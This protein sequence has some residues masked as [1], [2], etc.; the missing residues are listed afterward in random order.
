MRPIVIASIV[1][2]VSTPLT[3]QWLKQPT[4]GI[5]RTADGKPSLSAPSPQ[6]KDGT[7]D[8]SGLWL[9]NTPLGYAG[10][11]ATD[12]E[13]GDIQPWAGALYKQRMEDFG[14]DDPGTIGCLPLGPRHIAGIG[15]A[16]IIQAP[17]VIV[18]L[19]EDLTYRQIFLDGRELPKDP[20]PSWMG[21]SVGHWEGD[22]LVVESLG[23]NDRTWLDFG[24]HPHTEALRMTERFRRLDFGHMSVQ[25]MI[26]D[27][28][29]YAK[30]WSITIP[31][32]LTAD[33]ELL[34]YVCGENERDRSHLVGRTPEEK[35]VKVAPDILAKYVGNYAA[36]S[37]DSNLQIS[38]F[39]VTLVG[40]ELFVAFDGKGKLLLIPLSETVFS[41]FGSYEFVVDDRGVVTHLIYHTTERDRKAVRTGENAPVRNR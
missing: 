25:V 34:E 10:N 31:M 28:K 40:D 18:V 11:I 6:T 37:T 4:A 38:V 27:A 29:V 26:D 24:G 16:K 20:N 14:K 30:P 22:T 15:M 5:P 1:F 13:P 23:F 36:S 7:P 2:A 39:T 21:Y 12:L 32:R 17:N 33:T 41:L 8:L 35:R 3:A 19:Y 9:M